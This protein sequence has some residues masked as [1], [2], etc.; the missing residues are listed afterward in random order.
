MVSV[1]SY[2]RAGSIRSYTIL[3]ASELIRTA[4]LLCVW[5]WSAVQARG[6]GPI[7]SSFRMTVRAPFVRAASMVHFQLVAAVAGPRTSARTSVV[8]K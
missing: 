4:S 7:S 6:S 5:D 2:I 1:G 3:G 8:N